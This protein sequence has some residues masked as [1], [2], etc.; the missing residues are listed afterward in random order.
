[1]LWR[2]GAQT[3]SLVQE[4]QHLL[5]VTSPPWV[6]GHNPQG[7]PTLLLSPFYT[8]DA[9]PPSAAL[10]TA[11]L[12]SVALL[13]G[14]IA[15]R[16]PSLPIMRVVACFAVAFLSPLAWRANFVLAWPLALAALHIGGAACLAS[17]SATFL[18]GALINEGVL[19]AAL[20]REV[21]QFRLFALSLL[22]LCVAVVRRRR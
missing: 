18:S 2:Y 9:V 5:A 7:L 12:V 20:Y 1:V 6:M 8:L 21:A 11:Q 13:V 4:W 22:A 17:A 10:L 3:P 15:W 19:G 14:F 16:K